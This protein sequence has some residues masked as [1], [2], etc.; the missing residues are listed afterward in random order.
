MCELL[1]L[2]FN[3]KI[4]ASLSLKDFSKMDSKNPDGWG[5]AFYPDKASQIFKEPIRMGQSQLASFIE[6]YDKIISK[7]FIAHIRETTI[8]KNTYYNTHPFLKTLYDKDYVFAH[9][10]TLRKIKKLDLTEF[11]P[12]GKTDSE[13]SFCY[14]M[15]EIR[16][17]KIKRWNKN[18]IKKISKL[19]SKLNT[20]G[21]FNVLFSDGEL[22][23]AYF[24]IK[25][26]KP[27]YFRK[28]K[29]LNHLKRIEDKDI[30]IRLSSKKN[31][32]SGYMIATSKMDS[33]DWHEFAPGE[34]IAFKDGKMIY[35]NKRTIK[36]MRDL[37]EA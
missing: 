20:H 15:Q 18:N 8:G 21:K 10:G 27:M 16:K 24:D 25:K 33:N 5:I 36:E 13:K 22:L 12:I 3:H 9:N 2:C 35:S 17:N 29:E 28:V 37:N 6:N 1:G 7:I 14:I 19:F 32:I 31:Q 30:K 34:M 26:R 23:F 11:L 4:K